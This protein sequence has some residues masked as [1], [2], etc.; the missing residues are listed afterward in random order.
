M[1]PDDPDLSQDGIQQSR[2]L[3]QRLQPEPIEHLFSSPYLRTMHT[4]AFCARQKG[5]AIR[6]EDGIG[7]WLDPAKFSE[8]PRLLSRSELA[9][10]FPVQEDH[11]A[12]YKPVFPESA[13]TLLI[14]CRLV[15]N[16]ILASTSGNLLLVGHGASCKALVFALLRETFRLHMPLCSL[17]ELVK[18]NGSWR[19]RMNGDTSFLSSGPLHADRF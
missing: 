7:E 14:R 9:R 1:R 6:M 11:Q 2:E 19:L 3:A 16:Q 5:L 10:R 8:P 13:E 17:T 18:Q 4:A 15:I 12:I